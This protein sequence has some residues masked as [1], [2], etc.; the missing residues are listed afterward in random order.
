MRKW[1]SELDLH[2]ERLLKCE[3]LNV[4][5]AMRS[6]WRAV[7]AAPIA[8]ERAEALREQAPCI[9]GVFTDAFRATGRVIPHFHTERE[10]QAFG[11]RVFESASLQSPL[12]VWGW[13]TTLA[14]GMIPDVPQDT[15]G[16]R[17]VTMIAETYLR[18]FHD[19]LLG[20]AATEA[21]VA[22]SLERYREW[23]MWFGVGELS[24]SVDAELERVA[25]GQKKRREVE[26]IM[27]LRLF[28]WLHEAGFHLLAR[29]L[30]S[31]S[32]Q[33]DFVNFEVNGDRLPIEV[34]ILA[35]RPGYGKEQ[36]PK[37]REQLEIYMDE[38]RARYGA[39]VLFDGSA[40]GHRL[41]LTLS[42][43][44][45]SELDLAGGRRCY[46][47]VIPTTD[48]GNA[49]AQKSTAKLVISPADF[50]TEVVV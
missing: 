9:E 42:P 1:D 47:Y 36:L 27:Q 3:F 11:L 15:F 26:K 44:G 30:A 4:D 46:V 37:A 18:P 40:V 7:C 19:Y 38:H 5:Y 25:N 13:I 32:G 8:T 12:K 6:Y 43:G 23:A 29:E 48:R 24:A 22:H 49:T 35:D 39:L 10:R 41:H 2:W 17:A 50:V 14:K 20:A 28:R 16:R 21:D 34:K 33:A 31:P 45:I